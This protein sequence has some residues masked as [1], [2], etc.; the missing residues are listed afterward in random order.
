MTADRDELTELFLEA[1]AGDRTALAAAIR[2]SQADVWRLVAHLVGRH[3]ADDV[4]QDVYVRAWRALPRYRADASARTWLLAIARRACADHL[5]ARGR[6]R[7]L[8]DR[9]TRASPVEAASVA[10]PEE[11]LALVELVARLTP[12]RRAAFVLTQLLGCSYAETAAICGVPVGTVRSRVARA[13][14]DLLAD[15]AADASMEAG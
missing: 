14:A 13:R 12:D 3:E 9:L 8:V 4:T 7:R 6:G 2:S 1:R 5:R 10:G 15:V 11:G